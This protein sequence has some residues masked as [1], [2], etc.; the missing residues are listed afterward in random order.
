MDGNHNDISSES[1]VRDLA[2]KLVIASQLLMNK[3][4][5]IGLW[6]NASV[7]NALKI[8]DREYQ[9]LTAPGEDACSDVST[10]SVWPALKA[11]KGRVQGWISDRDRTKEMLASLDITR[12]PDSPPG[13][14]SLE[15][16]EIMGGLGHTPTIAADW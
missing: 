15:V 6:L 13:N 16:A 7:T 4:L 1:A 5:I 11:A 2:D 8:V 14:E 9:S 3:Q 12:L 10:A